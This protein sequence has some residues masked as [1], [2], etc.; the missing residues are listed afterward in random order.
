MMVVV[1]VERCIKA[2]KADERGWTRNRWPPVLTHTQTH[3]HANAISYARFTLSLHRPKCVVPLP[4]RIDSQPYASI[5]V[6]ASQYLKWLAPL[7]CTIKRRGKS[8]HP[9]SPP[10][11]KPP[12]LFTPSMRTGSVGQLSLFFTYRL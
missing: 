8:R 5:K 11:F 12:A 3:K 6:R 10:L 2:Y 7:P 9:S 4:N 1:V